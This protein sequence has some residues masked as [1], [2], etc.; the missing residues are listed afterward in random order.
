MG[1]SKSEIA[2]GRA[3]TDASLDAERAISDPVSPV[4]AA[5]ARRLLDELIE[6]DRTLADGR[7]LKFRDG[8]DRLLSRERSDSP[9]P[10]SSV[11][12]ERDSTDQRQKVERDVAD[13][14]LKR[15][16]HRSDV[17]VEAE[18]S[19]HDALRVG[20]EARRQDTD[21]QLSS[22]RRGA[23]TTSTAL[24]ETTS[25][26]GATR[27]A[28]AESQTKEGRQ[29]DVLG[30][31]AHDLRG[32]LTVISLRAESIAKMTKEPSIRAAA[33]AIE[34]ATARMERL[35]RDL[36]DMVRIES[37]TLRIIKQRHDVSALLLE[38]LHSYEP[39]FSARDITFTINTPSD[40]IEAVFDQDRIVQ[41]ISNLLGNA[42]KFTQGGGTVALH[43]EREAE[44]VSFTVRDNGPGIPQSALPHIFERFWQ[45]DSEARRGLG[46]G[47][48]ICENIV[49]AHGGRIWA[50]SELG[51]GATFRFTL[52]TI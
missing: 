23:D 40:S 31:V 44:A 25:I 48:H 34:L 19:E 45:I 1:Q 30:I 20:L 7:L 49:E 16:R 41:V 22:E 21:D 17:A 10:N 27:S 46:L 37:G 42:M 36:F 50:E 14:L 8:A 32:S 12:H 2:D 39:L 9:S 24:G 29:H 51:K 13:A 26:L 43:V 38:I 6:R 11:S 18:R 35:L 52:P 28:L 3:H 15:E 33:D 47:L 5:D 4:S